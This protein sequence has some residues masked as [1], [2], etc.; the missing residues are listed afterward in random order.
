[1]ANAPRES[2]LQI[3]E[4]LAELRKELAH[5]ATMRQEEEP[6]FRLKQVVVQVSVM[7]SRQGTKKGGV[8][9]WVVTGELADVKQSQ[10]THQITLT[11]EPQNDDLYLGDD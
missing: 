1:M 9:F 2:R 11:L 10:L 8:K 5:A 3:G 6:A 4:W 7:S